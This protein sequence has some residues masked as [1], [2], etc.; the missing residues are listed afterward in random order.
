MR[1]TMFFYEIIG[2]SFESYFELLI[3]GYMVMSFPIRTAVGEWI[4]F[5][6]GIH[7]TIIAVVVMPIL[8]IT[9]VFLDTKKI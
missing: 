3:N 9:I 8:F 5:F 7:A 6:L 4:S 1:E 2:I